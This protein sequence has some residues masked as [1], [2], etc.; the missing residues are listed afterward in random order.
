MHKRRFAFLGEK[1]KA[2][3]EKVRQRARKRQQVLQQTGMSRRIA[4]PSG[5]ADHSTA[6]RLTSEDQAQYKPD[7]ERCEHRLRRVF[8]HVLLRVFLKCADAIPRIA[9][10]LFCFAS[11]ISPGLFSFAAVLSRHSAGG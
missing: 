5:L 7:S 8:A 4:G 10:S 11:R 3:Y 1:G 2:A 6:A 9:P